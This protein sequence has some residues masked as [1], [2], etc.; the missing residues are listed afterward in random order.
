MNKPNKIKLQLNDI[1]GPDDILREELPNGI[2]VLSRA[3]FHSPSV[4]LNGYLQAGSIFDTDQK[5]GLADFAATA[6]MRGTTKRSFSQIYE[7]LEAVGAG[8]GFSGGTHTAGFMGRAL[9]E[10]LPMLLDL[11]GETLRTPTFPASQVEKLRAALLTSLDLQQQDT[12]D[13]AGIAFDQLVYP[14]HP[15]GRPDEG[16]PETVR[17]IRRRDLKKF[18]RKHYGPKGMVM[19]IVGGID[20]AQ[21]VEQVRAALGDWRNDSQP[22]PPSLPEWQPLP[23][24]QDVRIPMP[25][26]SQSDIIIG[27][28]GPLR[29]SQDYIPAAVGNMVLGKF[30]MMGRLGESVREKAGLAYYVHSGLGSSLG[31]GAWT[32]SAGVDPK[33]VDQAVELILEEVRRFV[34]KP[35]TPEE[36][37]DVQANLIGSLPLSLESNAGVASR[38]LHME[39]HQ[40]GL[41]FLRRYPETVRAVTREQ[42]L[43]AAARYLDPERLAVVVAG[44]P[45]KGEVD[46]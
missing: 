34:T 36:L 3:N 21:A 13:R 27:T 32:V 28:A 1:P 24:R 10:D 31:P 30:G 15:Y 18:H 26:K 7:G 25:S 46:G 19:A 42:I 33:D 39:R 22:A 40:L 20:P 41:D 37:S 14:N 6:L 4:T 12:R 9:V 29:S 35:V 11:M 17:A 8:L 23:E 44:P 43:E 2:V 5:L 16:Y 38:I 45:K